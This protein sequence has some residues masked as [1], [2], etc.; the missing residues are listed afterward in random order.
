MREDRKQ[1]DG[2]IEEELLHLQSIYERM[3][4]DLAMLR[5]ERDRAVASAVEE[6]E[7]RARET[8]DLS[9]RLAEARRADDCA[10][11]S[12]GAAPEAFV[13]SRLQ[14]AAKEHRDL[15]DGEMPTVPGYRLI[16]VVGQ[17]GMASVYHA[18]C[19]RDGKEVAIKLLHEGLDASAG[20]MELFL[21]EAAVMLQL[22]HPG[23]VRAID[24]GDCPHGRFLVMELVR[25]ESLAAL[26]RRCGPLPEKEAIRVALQIARALAYCARLGLTHRDVKPSNLLMDSSG[27]VRLCD[28]GLAALSYGA[29]PARPYGSPGYAAPEQISNPTSIDERVDIYALGSTIWHLVVGRRPFQGTPKQVFEIQRTQDVS[30]PRFEGADIS[31]R[32]AQVIRRMGRFQRDRRYRKWDECILDLMLVENGNPPFSAHLAEALEPGSAVGEASQEASSPPAADSPA[33]PPELGPSPEIPAHAPSPLAP[34]RLRDNAKWVLAFAVCVLAAVFGY[35]VSSLLRTSPADD[36]ERRAIVRADAGDP[37]GAAQA[38][39]AAA[40]LMDPADRDRLI[41]L[42]ERLEVHGT[43]K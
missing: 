32:L 25:G 27:R 15:D 21:R 29:D 38:L 20:R 39:R 6:R 12:P 2:S 18:V 37:K 11:Q 9:E 7:R 16:S 43:S 5:D 19:E 3:S 17:G 26:V 8:L 22:S 36:I 13:Q 14:S 33:P 4:S 31:P 42:A 23:L 24:A 28:F 35:S 10:G 1:Q 41:R 34:K 40:P 30:D